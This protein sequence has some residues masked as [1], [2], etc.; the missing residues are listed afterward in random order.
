MLIPRKQTGRFASPFF[1]QQHVTE[2]TE[3]T[4]L[5]IYI[6]IYIFIFFLPIQGLKTVTK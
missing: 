5:S 2:V 4:S 1:Y 3:I 6:K